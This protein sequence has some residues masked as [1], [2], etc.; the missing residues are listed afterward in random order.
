MFE[1]TY[2]GWW[3]YDSSKHHHER[4][5]G[6]TGENLYERIKNLEQKMEAANKR[7][8]DLESRVYRRV[9][10]FPREESLNDISGGV[11]SGMNTTRGRL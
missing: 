9:R 6:D 2:E 10:F 7:I 1:Y 3:T 8:A 11:V 5:R 4:T